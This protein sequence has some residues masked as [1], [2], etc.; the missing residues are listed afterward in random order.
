MR[1]KVTDP[2]ITRHRPLLLIAEHSVMSQA[3]LK[4][5]ATVLA[6]QPDYVQLDGLKIGV[7]GAQAWIAALRSQ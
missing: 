2:G 1:D 5:R 3:H 6:L 7:I 4:D